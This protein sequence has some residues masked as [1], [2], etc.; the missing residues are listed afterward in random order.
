MK[1]KL[2]GSKKKIPKCFKESAGRV[3]NNAKVTKVF[4]G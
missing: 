2:K 4:K 3:S 1:L